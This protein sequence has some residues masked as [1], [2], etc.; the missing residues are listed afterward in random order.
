MG[1]G[2]GSNRTTEQECESRNDWKDGRWRRARV[3]VPNAAVDELKGNMNPARQKPWLKILKKRHKDHP[4]ADLALTTGEAIAHASTDLIDTIPFASTAM[5]VLKAKDSVSDALFAAKLVA[6][7]NGIGD[8][9]KEQRQELGAKLVG[10]DAGKAGQTVL[11]VIDRI[12][13]L[14]KCELLGYVFRAFAEGTVNADQLRRLATAIDG[15]FA[16]DL[17]DLLTDPRAGALSSAEIQDCRR[18]LEHTG[19]TSFHMAQRLDM[20]AVTGYHY[21]DFGLLLFKLVNGYEP[22]DFVTGQQPRHVG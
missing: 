5:K 2:N 10:E 19:L 18:R 17:R 20:Q 16:D 1:A 21:T 8:L 12:S 3:K 14:D 4:V 15:A 11:F 22:Y 6:F 13:D 9:T 7:I